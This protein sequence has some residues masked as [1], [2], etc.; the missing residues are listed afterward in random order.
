MKRVVTIVVLAWVLSISSMSVLANSHRTGFTIKFQ[1]IESNLTILTTTVM[2]GT[3]IHI[4]TVA[5]AVSSDGELLRSGNNW[6]WTPPLLPGRS[7]LKFSRNGETIVLNVFI[8]TP[9]QNKVAE[10]LFGYR[11]GRYAT[12]LFRGLNSYAAPQGF[13]NLTHGPA[14]LQ[15]SPHFTLG[16]FISKQQPGHDPSFILVRTE[17]LIKLEALL[18]AANAKGWT[19][20]T[21]FVMSGFRTP[22]YNASI[23]NHTT[24]S[25]HLYGGA[26]DIWIDNDRDG[27][28]DDLNEDGQINKKDAREL[29]KLAESLATRGGSNWP[30]GGIGIYPATSA[31]GPFVH[32]DAR[33][34]RARWE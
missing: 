29:A 1:N 20:D 6:I 8:L 11:I 24:A 17:L 34:Y 32:I 13:I 31:H 21:F 22:W 10:N 23:G 7:E 4:N 27:V 9:F 18:E 5:D 14:N 26:A 2:A 16:Q 28:M 25:R 3:S 33:G 15:I 30:A 12:T 19:A